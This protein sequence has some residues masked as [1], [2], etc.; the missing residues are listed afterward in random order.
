M[1]APK[2]ASPTESAPQTEAEADASLGTLR[3]SDQSE[4]QKVAEELEEGDEAEKALSE[5]RKRQ[6][7]DDAER[8]HRS[9]TEFDQTEQALRPGE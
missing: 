5:L 9:I 7:R 4:A 2:P 1:R 8:L 3:A 6:A